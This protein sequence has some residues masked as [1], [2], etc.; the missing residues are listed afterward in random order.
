M[1][2]T[3]GR[4]RKKEFVG[5]IAN[6]EDTQRLFKD[7]EA[8]T[9]ASQKD[10]LLKKIQTK[11]HAYARSLNLPNLPQDATSVTLDNAKNYLN[12]QAVEAMQL[13][14]GVLTEKGGLEAL[15]KGVA[16][17]KLE[18]LA[19]GA[20]EEGAPY[21]K[22]PDKAYQAWADTYRNLGAQKKEYEAFAGRVKNKQITQEDKPRV[23]QMIK[24]AASAKANERMAALKKE[25]KRSSDLI[26]TIGDL[27]EQAVARGKPDAL[28]A[29][30]IALRLKELE[31][32]YKAHITA[33][34]ETGKT[35][36]GYVTG[37]LQP[38][39]T[40][41]TVDFN[42]ARDLLYTSLK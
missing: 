5:F 4:D 34:Q 11:G 18:T 17:D 21:L 10:A 41:K 26:E 35:L 3:S 33:G 37:A 12:V 31:T 9:R 38:M 13:A 25:G 32:Q 16:S 27:V 19:F 30:G 29:E 28:I 40:G 1:T 22:H 7:Y 8:E 42:L 36:Q 39:V 14:S 20:N 24:T 6:I 15:V 2:N 23:E